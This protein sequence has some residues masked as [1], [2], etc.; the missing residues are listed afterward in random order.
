MEKGGGK[1]SWSAWK[2]G[3]ET[4]LRI[5]IDEDVGSGD[6]QDLRGQGR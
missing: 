6:V 4:V 3:V 1:G 5:F 2:V